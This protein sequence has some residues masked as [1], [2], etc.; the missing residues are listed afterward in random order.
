MAFMFQQFNLIIYIIIVL[1]TENLTFLHWISNLPMYCG[2]DCG[3]DCPG[4]RGNCCGD[5]GLVPGDCWMLSWYS[6]LAE[7]HV[8]LKTVC[9]TVTVERYPASA[10]EGNNIMLI[11][12]NTKYYVSTIQKSKIIIM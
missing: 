3:G 11:F 4:S 9:W 10:R 1:I 7:L 6:E 12:Y 2:C 8:S 5:C